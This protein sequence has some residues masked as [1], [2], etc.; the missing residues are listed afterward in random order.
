MRRPPLSLLLVVAAHQLGFWAVVLSNNPQATVTFDCVSGAMSQD[1]LAG[2]AYSPFDTYDGVLGGMFVSALVGAPVFAL[3]GGTGFAVKLVAGLWSLLT[4]LLGW[5]FLDRAFGRITAVVGGLTLALPMPTTFLASTIMGNWHYTELAFEFAVAGVLSAL[6]WRPSGGGRGG[7]FAFGLLSGVA[8]FNCF[9]TL[10]FFG[11]FWLLGYA[12]LR[13]R[14]GAWGGAVYGAGTLLGSSPLWLKVLLHRPYGVAIAD[15]GG[16]KV[17]AE[18]LAAGINPRKLAEL[19]FDNGFSWGLHFQDVLGHP[20]GTV[21]SM[22][23][24]SGVTFGLFG[25]WLLLMVRVAPSLRALLGGL[26]PSSAPLDSGTV[27]PAVVPA[28]MGAFY[29]LAWLLS[30][31]NVAVLPWYLSNVRELGHATLIPWATVMGLS[32]AVLLGSLLTER[33]GERPRGERALPGPTVWVAGVGVAW[34][35][36]AGAIGVIGAIDDEAQPGLRSVVRG[37]CHDVHG[38]Y[39]GPHIV[40]P[41]AVGDQGQPLDAAQAPERAAI[42]CAPYGAGAECVRGVLWSLGFAQMNMEEG[43]VDPANDCL[44]LDAPWR[45]ECLRGLGW[46][47]QSSGEGGLVAAA[48]ETALCADLPE[49]IDRAACWRGVGFPLGDHLHNQP[50]RLMRALRD[51]PEEVQADI[52]RGAATHIGRTYSAWSYM[53][54]LCDAWDGDLQAV[55]VAGL[56]DSMAYR[57]DAATVRGR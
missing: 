20:P 29:G 41:S 35:I 48:P 44:G 24:A 46:A 11:A 33:S 55:C 52:A 50:T 1:I 39:M 22:T 32:G 25:G 7:A 40:G 14:W 42:F 53:T 18:L 19:V 16:T 26:L 37:V 13:H 34:V 8:I 4:V 56:E 36:G 57:A 49:A 30:D 10:I 31:M 51:F 21:F 3:L 23:L 54:G 5:W 45:A 43:S 9:G 17:P 15:E 2:F 6:I 27:S 28:L 38:V 12:L 47:L